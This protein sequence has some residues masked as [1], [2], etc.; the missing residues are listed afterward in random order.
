MFVAINHFPG[1]KLWPDAFLPGRHIIGGQ[2]GGNIEPPPK[3][4]YLKKSLVE[5]T[6]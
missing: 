1:L 2:K 4:M 3:R 6:N 5:G